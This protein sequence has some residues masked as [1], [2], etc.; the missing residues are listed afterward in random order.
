MKV[1]VKV[2]A[3]EFLSRTYV[4]D[5]GDGKQM[6]NWIATVACQLFGQDHYPAGVYIPNSLVKVDEDDFPHPRIPI[7]KAFQDGDKAE[8]TLKDRS[9]EQTSLEKRWYDQAFGKERHIMRIGIT[10]IP[11][12]EIIKT[13]KAI[14]L[15]VRVHNKMFPELYEEFK[16]QSYKEEFD[17]QMDTL[18]YHDNTNYF[19][20]DFD[21]PYGDVSYEYLYTIGEE[22]EK[23]AIPDKDYEGITIH[24]T[25]SEVIS[26]ERQ[27][28]LDKHEE[29]EIKKKEKEQRTAHKQAMERKKDEAK[30]RQEQMLLQ[31]QNSLKLD[32]YWKVMDL[33]FHNSL[34]DANAALSIL[35]LYYNTITDYF[36]FYAALQYQ[37]YKLDENKFITLHSFMH[38][39]KLFGIANTKD[40]L[41]IYFQQLDTLIIPPPE[42]VLN[43]KNGLN[44][45][46]FLEAILRIVDIKAKNSDQPDNEETYRLL[47]QQIFQDATMAIKHKS[48][49]DPLIA[50]LYTPR[51]VELFNANYGLLAGIYHQKAIN[52]SGIGLGMSYED[53]YTILEEA[54]M[55]QAEESKEE[56]KEGEIGKI[57]KQTVL[58]ALRGIEVYD[59]DQDDENDPKMLLY[60]DFLD[61]IVRTAAYFPFNDHEEYATMDEKPMYI[62]EKLNDKFASV[63]EPFIKSLEQKDKDMKFVCKMVINDESDNEGEYDGEGEDDDY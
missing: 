11:K 43:I 48:E 54:G 25:P 42:N 50:E 6:V 9:R 45:A 51:S 46:Q 34:E 8:V 61:A 39:L 32:I 63:K 19:S 7:N 21:I 24:Q 22:E 14:K 18:L 20:T 26:A 29:E 33:N 35:S 3:S 60:V 55:A 53:F 10:Y 4:I 27:E 12:A 44:F 56:L 49:E 17:L 15:F 13:N 62:V 57:S 59:G 41:R 5:C 36:S 30:E 52:K 38:F 31:E 47:L 2:I 16:G 37:F 1:E 28:E 40:E 58:K 23:K